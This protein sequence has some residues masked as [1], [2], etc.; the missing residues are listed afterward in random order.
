MLGLMKVDM[1][2]FTVQSLRPHLLQQSVQYERAKFQEILDKQPGT[3]T[4]P[5]R[6]RRE[7]GLRNVCTWIMPGER[8]TGARTNALKK[9][10]FFPLIGFVHLKS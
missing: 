6:Q 9:T 1:V 7:A 8:T 3:Q 5:E 10:I 2:N 4:R